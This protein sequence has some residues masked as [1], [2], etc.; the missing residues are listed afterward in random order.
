M[1]NDAMRNDSVLWW[2]LAQ[3]AKHFGYSHPE[4]MR[5]RLRQLRRRGVV[6]DLGEP[7]AQ[8]PVIKKARAGDVVIFW[9]NPNTA[10]MRSDVPAEY[11]IPKRGRRAP[12]RG[13]D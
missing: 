6:S 1:Y 7:P 5:Q 3:A 10:L 12:H 8:Y 4:N 2:P 9:P 11:F 13:G